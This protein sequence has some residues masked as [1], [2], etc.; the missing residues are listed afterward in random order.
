MNDWKTFLL[1][2]EGIFLEI[3]LLWFVTFKCGFQAN[4]DYTN[5]SGIHR[6]SPSSCVL[7]LE[8]VGQVVVED[9]LNNG[10]REEDHQLSSIST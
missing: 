5:T 2:E 8:D 9:M 7:F 1:Y 3:L 10:F 4:V 6:L